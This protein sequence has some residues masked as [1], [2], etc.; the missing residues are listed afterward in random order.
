MSRLE[1]LVPVGIR[2][3][4]RHVPPRGRG[5]RVAQA[6]TRLRP[7]KGTIYVSEE[8]GG[9][10]LQ[11]DLRDHLSRVIYYRGWM[12][13]ALETWMKRWLR[14]G[15]VYVDVGAHIGY[16]SALAADAVTRTG[17]VVAFEPS[18]DTYAKLRAAFDPGR[19]PHVEVVSAAVASAEGEATFFTADG[20]WAHQSYRNS[21]HPGPGLRDRTTVPTASLDGH[22]PH[23]RLRLLKI[24]VEGGELG[25]L[26]GGADLLTGSRCD[27]LVI[28]LNPDAL[29]RAGSSVAAL[30]EHLS[31]AGFGAHRCRPDGTLE[32]WRPVEVNTE[33]ADAV[34]LPA[35]AAPPLRSD[36]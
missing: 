15:D 34:F 28:E 3:G 25:V 18:P 19:F 27:A 12:D 7:P 1:Q 8:P 5:I 2:A 20:D 33:F 13:L 21:L 4:I 22:F 11:C 6:W 26:A 9:A 36:G 16:L 31:V 10:R 23:E 35:R 32:P 24:D 14:P 29:T 17:R 30:V